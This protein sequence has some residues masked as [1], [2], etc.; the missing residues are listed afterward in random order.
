MTP[1][2]VDKVDEG[3]HICRIGCRAHLRG[4]THTWVGCRGRPTT[5]EGRSGKRRW[6][7]RRVRGVE[8]EVRTGSPDSA[9][10]GSSGLA[11][12]TRV[13]QSS[14]PAK[15]SCLDRPAAFKVLSLLRVGRG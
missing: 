2:P 7:V 8:T 5:G 9:S 4:A 10:T 13:T 14:T 12:N 15:T 1:V 11:K 6:T 3:G